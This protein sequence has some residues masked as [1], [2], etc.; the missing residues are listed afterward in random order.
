M[1]Q[2][3]ELKR[4]LEEQEAALQDLGQALGLEKLREEVEM[5]EHKSAE[6]GFWDNMEQAQKITQRMAALKGK[7]EAYQ[8]LQSRAGDCMALIEMGDEAED[9]SLVDEAKE[10]I[11]SIKNE[12]ASMKL[13]TLL[14]GEY[15]KNNAILTFHAGTG[16]TEAQDWAEM[17]YRMYT[18]WAE[19]H[20]YS[21]EV[22]DVL[23]G[24]E[25]G[26]K[27]ASMMVKGPNAYGMLKSEHGVH[28]LVRISPFD[29]NA[30]RQTSFSS[31]E[32]MPE[33]DNNINI[34]INPADIEMQVYRSSGAGG[35]HINKTSSAVRLIH[36]PTGIVTTCQTQRSQLQNREYAM[37]MMK[38]KLYQIALQQHKDKIDDIKGVQNEIA[39]GHQIRSYVFMP[40]TLVKDHRTNY[41]SGNV[42]A[43]MDGDLDG[44]IYAY[45]KASSRGELQDV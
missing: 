5:L 3:E 21:V 39:W 31:L 1:L 7:D 14:T 40:Y 6:P 36:K 38:A 27:S 2:F 8:K 35:Q 12:I 22:L 11:E 24:D 18:R 23:D 15:D 34:E 29:A 32:V 19:A 45:L 44:F 30:R 13:S 41:E 10:E 33:L 26:I 17:L 20:G 42:Q 9:L 37:E 25:A 43:V 28:R 4:E 16:G